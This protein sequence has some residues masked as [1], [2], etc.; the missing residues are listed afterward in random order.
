MAYE[1]IALA[2]E[3]RWHKGESERRYKRLTPMIFVYSQQS[4]S[5]LYQSKTDVAI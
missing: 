5:F 2:A 4:A 1:T 3:L